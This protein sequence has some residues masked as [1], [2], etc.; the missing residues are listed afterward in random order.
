MPNGF[1][2]G[3][4][5][6]DALEAPLLRIDPLLVSFS[7]ERHMKLSRNYHNWPERSLEWHQGP[8]RKL[9]QIFLESENYRTYTLWVS[10]SEDRG[11]KRYWKHNSLKKA[12]EFKEIEADLGHLLNEARSQLNGWSSDEL[13]FATTLGVHNA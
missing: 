8:V 5:D 1:Y 3:Q 9:I 13:G 11:G 12:V 10:A 6:W 4:D 7:A 2:G